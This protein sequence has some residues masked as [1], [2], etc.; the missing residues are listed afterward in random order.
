MA[1]TSQSLVRTQLKPDKSFKTLEIIAFEIKTGID[2]MVIVGIYRPPRALCGEHQT[3][4]WAV[5]S[6]SLLAANECI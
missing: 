3:L 6:I 1:L 5:C 4:N 2:N